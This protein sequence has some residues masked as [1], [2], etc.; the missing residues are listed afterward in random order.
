MTGTWLHTLDAKGRVVIPAAFRNAVPLPYRLTFTA[1]GTAVL[2]SWRARKDVPQ[3]VVFRID[4]V[5]ETT[6][7]IMVPAWVRQ[8]FRFRRGQDVL[9]EQDG[10]R[11][12]IRPHVAAPRCPHCHGPLLTLRRGVDTPDQ[13]ATRTELEETCART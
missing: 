4:R 8:Q 10:A 3:G 11:V 2:T 9:V 5:D 6:G 1:A 7:R 12:V 13:R